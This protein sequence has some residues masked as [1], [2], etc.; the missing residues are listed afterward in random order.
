MPSARIRSFEK[1]LAFRI[2]RNK[3]DRPDVILMRYKVDSLIGISLLVGMLQNIHD[4][5]LMNCNYNLFK[6]DSPTLFEATVLLLIPV[7]YHLLHCILCVPIVNTYRQ[8]LVLTRGAEAGIRR[9]YVVGKYAETV[10]GGAS[11]AGMKHRQIDTGSRDDVTR[12]LADALRPGDWVL[13]KGSRA[14]GM[15]TIIH[16]LIDP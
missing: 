6:G 12:A 3:G 15:E 2:V 13:I 14:M 16:A 7:E 5:S 8:T 10:A 1:N 11:A 4:T 9:L